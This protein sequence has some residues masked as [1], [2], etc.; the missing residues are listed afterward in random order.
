MFANAE[1]AV[2]AGTAAGRE[3]AFVMYPAFLQAF[4]H[5]AVAVEAVWNYRH[6]IHPA[7]VTLLRSSVKGDIG[8]WL[9]MLSLQ[10]HA[11]RCQEVTASC[12]AAQEA[13]TGKP[14]LAAYEKKAMQRH[15]HM[16]QLGRMHGKALAVPETKADQY[17]AAFYPLSSPFE[18]AQFPKPSLDDFSVHTYQKTQK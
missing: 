6:L 14:V 17:R 2:L 7:T 13:K 15:L 9:G 8:S 4:T 5:L 11:T 18:S 3:G 12:S 1:K 10:E 16:D